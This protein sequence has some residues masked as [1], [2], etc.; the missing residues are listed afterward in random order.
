MTKFV[1][2]MWKNPEA[3]QLQFGWDYTANHVVNLYHGLKKHCTDFESLTVFA[4]EESQ[5]TLKGMK[6]PKDSGVKVLPMWDDLKGL[7]RCFTR[8]KCFD[9]ALTDKYPEA[10]GERYVRLDLDMLIVD[11]I[12]HIVKRSEPFV[13]YKDS[14]EPEAYAGSF[15]ISD[16]GYMPEVFTEFDKVEFITK[17]A[18]KFSGSD[19]AWQSYKINQLV[20]AGA[21][22][23]PRLDHKDGIYDYWRIEELPRLPRNAAIVMFNG[24]RRD[25]S[26]R[27]YQE[28]H[29]WL[30]EN[31]VNM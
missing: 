2:F 20:E 8:L 5:K 16:S 4:D 14:N 1:T 12:D 23:P 15:Y 10:F 17:A 6:L 22:K 24:M 21:P 11:N 26:L 31:F 30:R 9:K 13:G 7:K 27:S 25:M 19:Q 3:K 29:Q 28:K 18:E